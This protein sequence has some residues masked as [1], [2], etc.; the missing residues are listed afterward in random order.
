MVATV[1]IL[2]QGLTEFNFGNAAV[3]RL[4]WFFAGLAMAGIKISEQDD[5]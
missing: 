1:G 2:L 5:F 4:Y 3:I